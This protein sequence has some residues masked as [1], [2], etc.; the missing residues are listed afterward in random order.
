MTTHTTL[1]P[2]DQAIEA[3][4]ERLAQENS[5]HAATAETKTDR[6][7]F[8]R[9]T[10]AYTNALIEYRRGIRPE[11]LAS[12]ARV[13]PSRRAGEAPHIVAMDGDWVCSC[14]A[15]ASM[16]WAIALVIG[17]EVALDDMDRF[18]GGD[19]ELPESLPAPAIPHAAKAAAWLALQQRLRATEAQLATWR[20][21]Q[22]RRAP[23]HISN[24]AR[25][26]YARAA[27]PSYCRPLFADREA[28]SMRRAALA[29]E[30]AALGIP[31]PAGLEDDLL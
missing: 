3:A 2:L 11:V 1:G 24:Q 17:I 10:T 5:Q 8:R 15:H 12:G 19:S 7:Y 16:H 14:K 30:R 4:L 22:Q 21:E 6:A 29:E 18:D 26:A 13:L 20:Q 25:A 28:E 9:A 27:Q 31:Q 23:E